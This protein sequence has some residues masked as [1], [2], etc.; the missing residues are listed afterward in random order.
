MEQGVLT[1]LK[2]NELHDRRPQGRFRL[3]RHRRQSGRR[4]DQGAGT[5]RARQGRR[6]PRPAR[7]LRAL[8]HQR[9]CPAAEDADAQSGGGRQSHSAHAKSVFAARL[10][11]L[12]AGDAADGALRGDRAQAQA[13]RLR[14]RGF[15]LRLRADR[16]LPG[17]VPEGRRL[18]R[19]QALAAAGD[20]RL[21]AL[22]RA[23][24]RLRCRLPG[25]RRLE[26]AALHEGLCQRRAE[27][28]GGDGR[29]RRRRRAAQELRRGGDRP[30][31]LLPLH[32]R[33][34]NR[35][36]PTLH[37][38]HAEKLQHQCPASMPRCSTSTARWSM[39]R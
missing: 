17:R 38:R 7:R 35:R 37:R 31:Q 9:I 27:I 32:A 2:E 12:V 21:H 23:D 24:Q 28:S 13:R 18:R 29:D 34:R 15:R 39:R 30:R 1:Y 11:D 36:Q 5:G 10:G 6:H 4:Q 33:A 20:A 3:R 26:S 22:H 25:L 8:C 14:H 16:R 19:Q